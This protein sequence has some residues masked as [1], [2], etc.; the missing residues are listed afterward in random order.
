MTFFYLIGM[1]E[2]I[3]SEKGFGECSELIFFN[4]I[5]ERWYL[6]REFAGL[7]RVTTK[8]PYCVPRS[9]F[10]FSLIVPDKIVVVNA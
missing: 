9:K 2:L 10:S 3:V 7:G 1:C 8:K 4:R 5:V 6:E